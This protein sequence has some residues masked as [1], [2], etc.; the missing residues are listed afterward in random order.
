[1]AYAVAAALKWFFREPL[2]AGIVAGVATLILVGG[3]LVPPLYAGFKRAGQ[4]LAKG[5]G[6]GLSWLLLVPFFYLCFPLARLLFAL[7]GI[8]PL[9]RGYDPAAASYWGPKRPA[10]GAGRYRKQY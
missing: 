2:P 10:A 6:L 5:V 3:L 8:D 9:R 1:M 4:A 7:R